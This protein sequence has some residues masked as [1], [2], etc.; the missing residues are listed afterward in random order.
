VHRAENTN[1]P[2]R[3]NAIVEAL[4]RVSEKLPVVFPIHPQTRAAL[5][6]GRRNALRPAIIAF[7]PVGYLDMLKLQRNAAVIATDSGGVQKEAFFS[8]TPCVT[9][10]EETEWP[11]LI[12][13]NWNRLA[14]PKDETSVAHS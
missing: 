9:L 2:H 12:D 13:L 3:L 10:R 5:D 6:H 7:P 1:E 8:R 14:P 4:N 11:E